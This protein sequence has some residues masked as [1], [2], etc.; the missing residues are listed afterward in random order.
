MRFKTS[1]SR[2]PLAER[3]LEGV[4]E[5]LQNDLALD[6]VEALSKARVLAASLLPSLVSDLDHVRKGGVGEGRGG[7]VRDS[8]WDV[9]DA[10][11]D[12]A[13]DDEGWLGVGGDVGGLEAAT[14]VTGN[15]DKDSAWAHELEH[16]A[17][18]EMRGLGTWDEGAADD[19]IAGWKLLLDVVA[20]GV[21]GVDVGR[22]NVTELTETW[23]ADIGDD[24]VST[25]ASAGEGSE[26][27]DGTGTKDEDLSR[28][29]TRNAAHEDT[30]ATLWAL[31]EASTF[32]GGH[33]AG[34]LGHWGEEW[35]GAAVWAT[36]GFE[37]DAGRLLLHHD[38][39]EGLLVGEVEVSEENLA[40]LDEV[41]F[42]LDRLLDLVDEVSLGVD[43]LDG[44]EHLGTDGDEIVIAEAR[45]DTGALLDKDGVAMRHELVDTSRGDGD[46]VLVV[47]DLLRDTNLHEEK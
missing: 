16:V 34:N 7:G 8:T 39:G 46:T 3:K 36:D 23:D 40:F 41:V 24:D 29:D 1:P 44:W 12:N 20:G 17:G 31:E 18:D 11:V 14:L 43:V 2:L 38:F 6:D 37:G 5:W 32:L 30:L 27:T 35:E 26:E 45:R 10:V 21:E 9:G 4:S 22:E 25:H 15:I 13:V 33:A 42:L 28:L 47:L 19:E